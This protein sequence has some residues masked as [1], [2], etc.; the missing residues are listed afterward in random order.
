MIRCLLFKFVV[1]FFARKLKKPLGVK[2][3]WGFFVPIK[4][5]P[6]ANYLDFSL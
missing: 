2:M 4:F 1:L 5:S 6:D 3:P